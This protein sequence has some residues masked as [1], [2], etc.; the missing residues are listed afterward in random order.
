MM[1]KRHCID[2]DNKIIKD[3]ET[4]MPPPR[5]NCFVCLCINGTM[6]ECESSDC[7]T[8]P[9]PVV[10]IVKGPVRGFLK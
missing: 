6:D 9:P 7:T 10:S 8:K 4:F 2:R 3:G 1:N 5:E